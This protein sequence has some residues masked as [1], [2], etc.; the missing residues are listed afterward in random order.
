MTALNSKGLF[1]LS[2]M[3]LDQFDNVK[4]NELHRI[5]QLKR[6]EARSLLE[7]KYAV[8]DL[9]SRLRLLKA[10]HWL[11]QSK[12]DTSDITPSYDDLFKLIVDKVGFAVDEKGKAE[13]RGEIKSMFSGLADSI[14]VEAMDEHI[15]DIVNA[16]VDEKKGQPTPTR[17]LKRKATSS[18]FTPIHNFYST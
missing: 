18:A 4:G 16:T 6:K 11:F 12:S 14:I 5:S 9:M 17:P 1:H 13:V 10:I 2:P 8:G 3:T 15:P 7:T